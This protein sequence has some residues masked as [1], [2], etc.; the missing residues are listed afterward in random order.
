MVVDL[1]TGLEVPPGAIGWDTEKP[2]T[3]Q[4]ESVKQVARKKVSTAF[5]DGYITTES[6][7]GNIR[8]LSSSW[9]DMG[10]T[11]TVSPI[12]M[13]PLELKSFLLWTYASINIT[14]N[15]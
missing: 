15:I 8:P 11:Y 6:G 5:Y 7:G 9:E 10:L 4:P 13:T 1:E 14:K 3:E 2:Y 12:Y